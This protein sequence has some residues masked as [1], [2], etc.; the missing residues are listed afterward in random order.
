MVAWLTMVTGFKLLKCSVWVLDVQYGHVCLI[1]CAYYS[2]ELTGRGNLIWFSI[3]EIIDDAFMMT[4]G[5][6]FIP[7]AVFFV[8]VFVIFQFS[9]KTL[10]EPSLCWYQ[11]NSSWTSRFHETLPSSQSLVMLTKWHY[12]HHFYH[13]HWNHYNLYFWSLIRFVIVL[14]LQTA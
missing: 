9:C 14:T 1:L 4:Y 10:S 7:S 11:R 8:R 5:W 3:R 12:K 2:C 13:S 6:L